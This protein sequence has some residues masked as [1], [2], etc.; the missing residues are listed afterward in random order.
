VD[1]NPRRNRTKLRIPTII[2]TLD[3]FTEALIAISV[4]I[5]GF[6][7]T[8]HRRDQ[9][10]TYIAPSSPQEYYL[11]SDLLSDLGSEV[12]TPT[13]YD[14]DSDDDVYVPNYIREQGGRIAQNRRD[15]EDYLISQL[16]EQNRDEEFVQ[17]HW[18][19]SEE[20]RAWNEV[21]ATPPITTPVRRIHLLLWPE[22]RPPTPSQIPLPTSRE[23]SP[24]HDPGY[25]YN[26]VDDY[27]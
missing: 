26:E 12:S 8:I 16:L 6:L 19:N 27:D 11:P 10:P 7:W 13:A 22:S 5:T 1:I 25:E 23:P 17:G 9:I 4:L 21:H 14:A 3:E 15:F 2:N 24:V 20:E 18:A